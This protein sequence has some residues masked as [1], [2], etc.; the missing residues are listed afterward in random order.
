M[1][2]DLRGLV[3]RAE[4]DCGDVFFAMEAREEANTIRVLD[5]FREFRV[6]ERHFAPT[7]GYGYSDA[8]RDT[9]EGIIAS[10]FGAEEA[11]LRPHLASGTHTLS[12]CLFGLLLPGDHLVSATGRPYDTL[13]T[14]IGCEGNRPGTLKEMGVSYSEIPLAEDGGLD[15]KAVLQALRPDTRLVFIQRS[16]GYASRRALRPAEM[17]PLIAQLKQSRPEIFTLV[18]NCYGEFVTQDEPSFFG[19][20]AVAGSL[21][22]NP[23]GGLAPTGGYIAGTTRA[24]DR[25]ANRLTAPGIGREVGSYAGGYRL[26]YQGLFMAP[27]TV[28]QALKTAALAAR[29]FELLGMEHSPRFDGPRSDIIQSLCLETPERVV[30]F[31]RGIQAASPVD[32]FAVPAPWG[33]PGY[34]DEVIMASGAFVSGSSIELSADAPMREPYTVYLQGALSYAHGKVALLSALESMKREGCL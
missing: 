17:G 2:V 25:I 11:L 23:G 28:T 24:I 29:V 21:I 5:A 14:M 20:D 33:M 31:C 9:L 16:G 32:S 27:H 3:Q 10:L 1:R 19:A 15:T 7:T 12:V 4:R 22:K 30:A 34:G 13:E 18:D 26:F 6:A 8:G